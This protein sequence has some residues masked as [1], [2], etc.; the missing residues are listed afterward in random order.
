MKV[1]DSKKVIAIVVVAV[2]VVATVAVYMTIGG[3]DGEDYRSSNTDCR[4]QI[5][6]NADEDDYFD[7]R[8]VAKINEM[9]ANGE[10]SQ[11]AD[12]NNDGKV[13]QADAD[14]VQRIIDLR[15]SNQ[16]KALDEKETTTVNYISIDN[17]VLSAT[18][19][20][21][22]II[23][24]NSQRALDIAIALG[25][26]DRVV[27]ATVTDLMSYWDDAEYVGCE[28][29]V[30]VGTRK[31]P[32]L[33]EIAKL[34]ADSIYA[35][36]ASKTLVNVEGNMAGDK[37]I[38]RLPTWENGGIEGAALTLGFFMDVEDSAETYV[39]WMDD[40]NNEVKDRLSD[41]DTENVSFLVMSSPTA[42]AVQTDGVSSAMDNTGA[43][44]SGNKI[45]PN[46][47]TSYGRTADYKEDILIEDPDYIIFSSYIMSQMTD[48]EIQEKFDSR[49]DSWEEL[50]GQTTAYKEGRIIMTD[51]GA[52]FCIVTLVGASIL[53]EEQFTQEYV[54]EKVQEYMDLFTNAPD[55]FEVQYNHIVYH[56][57]EA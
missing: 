47:N 48:S 27:G 44:N 12:A 43:F 11:M 20:V 54:T 39:K 19:P 6:G 33:E 26:D 41:V 42:M 10:Y 3:E 57:L 56:P 25:V 28:D 30:D 21:G 2:V 13:D 40:L 46:K 22:K 5:L 52:P 51:Y 49:A 37:Q 55:D 15:A 31:E 23:I 38:L 14:M 4:L 36:Q 32:N 45:I 50:F 53:F 16:G 17:E 8:D 34:D 7:D 24:A 18:Y 9:I 35:G 1:M 29:I